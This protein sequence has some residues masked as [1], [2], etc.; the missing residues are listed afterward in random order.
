[1]K[2]IGSNAKSPVPWAP[3]IFAAA[4]LALTVTLCMRAAPAD[5]RAGLS[6][7]LPLPPSV[8]L[9]GGRPAAFLFWR[10]PQP[11]F[12]GTYTI[13]QKSGSRYL[14]AY[15]SDPKDW[16]AVTRPPQKDVTQKWAILADGVGIYRIR[17]EAT[18]RYLDAHDTPDTNFA[19]VTREFQ[20]NDS[21]RWRLIRLDNGAYRIRQL[22]T[23]K[24][25]DAHQ[26]VKEDYAVVLRDFQSNT[27]QEWVIASW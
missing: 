10:P 27:S 8:S 23:G 20:R 16:A 14:D 1:M 12:S 5:G 17:Q 11:E 15:R 22:L 6:A 7:P 4:V 26:T 13:Q 3:A 21:Q 25:L 24:F 19:V 9:P 18:K 2:S